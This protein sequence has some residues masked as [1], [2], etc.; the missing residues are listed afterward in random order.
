MYW[1]EF[2]TIAVAHFFAVA[3]PGP[4][5]AVVLRQSVRYGRTTAIWTSLGV[6][7]AI[8]LHVCYCLLGVALF[9][10]ASPTA[11]SVVKLIGAGY[12][13][14]LGWQSLAPFARELL[15]R[16][17][18]G[19]EPSRTSSGNV[20]EA[21]F[22]N[23][24]AELKLPPAKSAFVTGFL[25]NGLNPKATLFFLALFTVVISPQTPR[26]I[27]I[28]Y[29]LYLA[30]ATFAWFTMLS[31]ILGRPSIKTLIVSAGDWLDRVMGIILIAL[32][33]QVVLTL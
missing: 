4:D 20:D 10:S 16:K 5:F 11:F 31:F 15:G 13:F 33:A 25:T 12:L 32:A 7:S 14:Y 3:S 28:A 6:G 23:A 21:A 1:S 30:A 26:S 24:S 19:S 9:L 17:K 27:Q 29:G 2:L 22:D 8:L 18:L